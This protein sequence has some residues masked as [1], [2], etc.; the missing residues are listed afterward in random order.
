[1][2]EL[3]NVDGYYFLP[4]RILASVEHAEVL[5]LGRRFGTLDL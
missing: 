5:I 2:P 4:V 1:M 3:S